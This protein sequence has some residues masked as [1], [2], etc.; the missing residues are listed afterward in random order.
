MVIIAL[1]YKTL[2]TKSMFFTAKECILLWMEA[3]KQ[4]IEVSKFLLKPNKQNKDP[5]FN[6]NGNAKDA[7]IE[8]PVKHLKSFSLA[9]NVRKSLKINTGGSPEPDELT[10]N[11]LRPIQVS[12]EYLE[13]IS[14]STEIKLMIWRNMLSISKEILL[15]NNTFSSDKVIVEE[16][17]K[18]SQELNIDVLDLLLNVML[19]NSDGIPKNYITELVEIVEGMGF[20]SLNNNM[21]SSLST[22]C[23]SNLFNLCNYKPEEEPNENGAKL[24]VANITTPILISKCKS[25][26]K[27]FLED[28]K[29]N[30]MMPMPRYCIDIDN[31]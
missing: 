22:F 20:S 6:G 26:I 19:A 3:G 30:G 4:I 11:I 25:I 24:N 18:K 15:P 21:H 12:D 7:L 13:Q 27:K 10:S 1:R 2:E 17:N 31:N 14:K 28:E 29:R 5:F 23:L 16:V 9:K 8:T